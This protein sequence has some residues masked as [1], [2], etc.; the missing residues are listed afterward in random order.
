LKK[1]PR[2]KPRNAD[3]IRS[4]GRSSCRRKIRSQAICIHNVSADVQSLKCSA[5]VPIERERKGCRVDAKIAP[6]LRA[7]HRDRLRLNTAGCI[8]HERFL[9]WDF[10]ARAGLAAHL[11]PSKFAPLLDVKALT[12]PGAYYAQ[13][14]SKPNAT[15]QDFRTPVPTTPCPWAAQMH[16]KQPQTAGASAGTSPQCPETKSNPSGNAAQLCNVGRATA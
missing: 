14:T 1:H 8:K 9:A 16:Y 12:S 6:G 11:A 7:P 15:R 2:W 10:P 4:L 13:S 3:E 5:S